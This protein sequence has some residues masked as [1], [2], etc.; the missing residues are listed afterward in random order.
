VVPSAKA[1]PAAKGF[2]LKDGF[3][4]LKPPSLL[5]DESASCRYFFGGCTL[6]MQVQKR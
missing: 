2:R 6:F 1:T 3:C 5:S 4:M